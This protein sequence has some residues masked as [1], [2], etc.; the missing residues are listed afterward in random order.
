MC[1]QDLV[2]LVDWFTHPSP[3]KRATMEEGLMLA[4]QAFDK[5]DWAAVRRDVG[6][7]LLPYFDMCKVRLRMP[8]G[9]WYVSF[10]W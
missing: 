7:S 4:C 9:A 2:D 5:Y 8:A 1:V 3:N 10:S 6:K